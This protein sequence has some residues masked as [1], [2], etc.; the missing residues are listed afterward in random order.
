MV[1]T[2]SSILSVISV[3][4]SCG[5]EPGLATVTVIVGKSIFGKRSTPRLKNEKAPTTTS[6][7]TSMVANTGRFTQI[8]ANHCIL[9]LLVHL[10]HEHTID[11]FIEAARSDHFTL[12]NTILDLDHVVLEQA[13]LDDPLVGDAVRN[14][15]KL[16]DI[17]LGLYR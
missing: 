8:S 7:I 1:L 6:D 9:R 17:T 2:D 5:D 10:P 15:V 4:I 16:V 14:D 13:D 3:S 11:K 12:G